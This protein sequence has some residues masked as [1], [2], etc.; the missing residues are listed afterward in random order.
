M[1]DT[2]E[3]LPTY[4]LLRELVLQHRNRRGRKISYLEIG[5]HEGGSA[6]AVLGTGAIASATLIDNWSYGDKR[7]D[8]EQ[9]LAKAGVL[10]LATILTGESREILPTLNPPFDM[11]FVDGDHE[12]EPAVN[13]MTQSLRLLAPNGRMLVDDLDH[14]G[15]KFL[16]HEVINFAK[17]NALHTRFHDAHFGVA[18]LW[19]LAL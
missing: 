1:N 2:I 15:Y 12:R 14:P 6:L 16:R 10:G 11:I 5:T 17:E 7:E 4:P 13:D 9:R 3:Q 19:R 18:E 8:V